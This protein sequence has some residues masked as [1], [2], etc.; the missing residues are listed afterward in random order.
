MRQHLRL[1]LVPF[2]MLAAIGS[3]LSFA[4]DPMKKADFHDAMR[5]LWEDHIAW[6]RLFVVS[7]VADLPDRKAATDRLLRNQSDIGN[8]VKPFYGDAAGD[9]LASLLKEHITT[10]AELV[11]AVKAGDDAKQKEANNRWYANADEIAVFLS[12]A[13][14]GNWPAAEMKEMMR[15]HLDLTTIEVVARVKSD[16]RADIE[17]YDNIH[18][19]ILVMADMLSN[20]I[21][22]QFPEHFR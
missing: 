1:Y 20:G 16:W 5:A 9:A 22:L 18:R 17:A 19:Q 13:N 7:A 2:I 12:N 3:Q 14:P 15:E 8:A 4:G 21:I 6:T 10:A 11:N